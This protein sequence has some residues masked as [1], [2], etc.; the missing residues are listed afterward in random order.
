MKKILLSSL[1]AVMAVTSA[2]AKI[3]ST[4]Y[5]DEVAQTKADAAQA[6][7]EAAA[8]TYTDGLTGNVATSEYI[9]GLTN[10]T[11]TGA[12]EDL[13]SRVEGLTGVGDQ[14]AATKKE[15][16]DGLAAK[17]DKNQGDTNAGKGLIVDNSGN[18]VVADVATD[19]ELAAV[20]EVA[21]EAK[22]IAD[23]AVTVNTQQGTAISENTTAISTI[24]S[25]D[26]MNSG[27]TK[28]KI[29]AI[30]TNTTAIALNT[31]LRVAIEN[32][33]NKVDGEGAEGTYALTAVVNDQ[34]V[35]E[36][37]WEKIGR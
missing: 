13:D 21:N 6:A 14:A 4:E 5:V 24:N 28:A 22:T 9:Q 34:G 33:A 26:V 31:A 25:S 2:N 19:T 17:L 10:K 20:S 30:E 23:G 7:A 18:L 27:A 15:L 32:N 16:E 35:S 36:F 3:A 12:V 29:D 37:K 8:K 11:L 1:L